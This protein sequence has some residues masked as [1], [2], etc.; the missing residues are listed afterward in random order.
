VIALH[1]GGATG[2]YMKRYSGLA[3]VADRAGFTVVFPNATGAHRYWNLD[4]TSAP[5]DVGFV[6]ALIE[7]TATVAC[8]DP[9]R[10]FVVGV[11]NGG[12][13]AARVGCELSQRVAGIVV[14]AGGFG[15]L[16]ACHPL[17]P[18]SVLEI[19]GSD[20]PSYP[21]RGDPDDGTGDVRTWLDGWAGRNGCAGPAPPRLMARR[22]VRFDWRGC[23]GG[24]ALAHI[25]VLGG[26]HQ[27]PGAT[28][29]DPGPPSTFSAAQQIWAFLA[30][31][32][33]R[34]SDG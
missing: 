33:S 28:P 16:P 3:R 29:P 20:D 5:D 9:A 17:R 26:G 10:V 2:P 11:S 27:W 14:V 8:V 4:P 15:H 7:R 24:T 30:H 6:E 32:R 18:V 34:P 19:H 31:L 23:A 25:E 21:Y 1:G 12:R 22:A 13:L